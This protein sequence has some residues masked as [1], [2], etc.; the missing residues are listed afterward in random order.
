[1]ALKI[2]RGEELLI[3]NFKASHRWIQNIKRSCR[4]V[5]RCLTFISKKNSL[6]QDRLFSEAQ[7][8]VSELRKE[9][10]GWP[11]ERV[12]NADQSGFLKEL[13]TALSLVMIVS[14]KVQRVVKPVARTTHSFTVLPFLFAD[15]HLGEKL[16]VVMQ[17]VEGK[18]PEKENF[19]AANLEV[20]ANTTHIMNKQ[21]MLYWIRSCVAS[22][23]A[24]AMMLLVIDSWN[25]FKD[26]AVIQSV[27]PEG[28]K[29]KVVNIPP[30]TTAQV[31]PLDVYFFYLLK[32]CIRESH[33]TSLHMI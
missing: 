2:N 24:P 29:V 1:M 33:L 3:E 21:L 31:Q 15:G 10:E 25:P 9:M 22:P 17:E 11:M 5:S 18:F 4:I 8:V 16:F 13:H 12:C 6:N 26:P 20:R 28:R 14:K 23:N 30:G 32:Q 19:Q 7:N 27:L